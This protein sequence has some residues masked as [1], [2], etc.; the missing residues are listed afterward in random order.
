M[1][2]EDVSFEVV[3]LVATGLADATCPPI[4]LDDDDPLTSI[5]AALSLMLLEGAHR[6]KCLMAKMAQM[7]LGSIFVDGADL[8]G[9]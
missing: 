1:V 4:L 6:H 8:V 2:E 5:S 7:L 3:K 9:A